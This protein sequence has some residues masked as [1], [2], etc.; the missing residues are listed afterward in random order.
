MILKKLRFCTKLQALPN[1]PNLI[2]NTQ[3][4]AYRIGV[5]AISKLTF[6]F[7]LLGRH[8]NGRLSVS[9]NING[10]YDKDSDIISL[11]GCHNAH[12]MAH[13]TLGAGMLWA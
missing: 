2:S 12:V 8:T 4:V 13:R 6:E 7:R 9:S 1:P 3:L 11:R 10:D 5:G